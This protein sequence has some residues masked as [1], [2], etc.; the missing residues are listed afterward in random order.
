MG[1]PRGAARAAFLEL[2]NHAFEIGIARAKAACKPVSTALGDLLA[3]SENLKLT[4]L[5]GLG[6]SFNT[7]TL[8]DEGHETRDLGPVVQSCGAMNDL[9]LHVC[10]PRGFVQFC[11]VQCSP[12]PVSFF[13]F[14]C[15][16]NQRDVMG[17]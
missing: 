11:W 9:N 7:E 17:L 15:L 10:S 14:H 6:R 5:A 13:F 2:L 4:H 12:M 8:V 16:A 3:V 1:S